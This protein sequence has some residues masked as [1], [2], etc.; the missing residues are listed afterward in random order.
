MP[1]RV[2]I[3][4]EE[5]LRGVEKPMKTTNRELINQ[6]LAG[7]TRLN[8]QTVA[9][10]LGRESTFIP[11]LETL[12]RN[13]RLWHTEE[14]GRIT[15]FHAVKLLGIMKAGNALPV[16]IDAIFLAY[17][18]ANEDVLEELPIVFSRIGPEAVEPLRSVLE[19]TGLHST[20]RTLAASG[21]EGIAVLHTGSG[22][23]VLD[24]LRKQ[25]QGPDHGVGLRSHVLGLIAR[26]RR[27]EDRQLVGSTL[28]LI[29]TALDM[30]QEEVYRYFEAGTEPWEW[31]E[32]RMDPLEFYD[33]GLER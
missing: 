16:L 27:P 4:G 17:S 7:D 1:I 24:I 14:A 3:M 12:L 9:E 20:I 26:F 15:V 6:L 25:L 2:T 18:T 22:D 19:D 29:P 28:S 10:I 31:A 33:I 21:L 13:V 8:P 23:V 32:Y 11:D 30:T 5:R